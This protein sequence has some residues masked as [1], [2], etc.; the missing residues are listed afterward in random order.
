MRHDLFVYVAAALILALV[1]AA[2]Y[3]AFKAIAG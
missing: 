1:Y 3:F 2:S